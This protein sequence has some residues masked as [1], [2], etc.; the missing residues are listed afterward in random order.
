MGSP[1]YINDMEAWQKLH[2]REKTV[3]TVGCCFPSAKCCDAIYRERV[4]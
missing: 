3:K 1:K 4:C 2:I